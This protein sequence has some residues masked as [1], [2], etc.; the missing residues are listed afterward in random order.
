[1][2]DVSGLNENQKQAVLADSKYLRI[3]AGAGSGKTRVLTMRI[4]HLIQDENI[5]PRQILAITFTN[6]AANEMKERIKK[7]LPGDAGSQ[8]WISTIHSLCVRIL[9]EDIMCMGWP[10]NFTVLDAE[11]Q[12]SILREAYKAIGVD[13]TAFPY[14]ALLD[15]I[16]NNK[17]AEIDVQRAFTLAGSFTGDKTK[18]KV[19]EFYVNRQNQMYALDFDDL[20][21]WT[22]R[23]FRT[24][25]EVQAKWQRRFKFI[26]VDEFQDI[27][28]IQYKLISQL[29]GTENSLYVVGDPDQTIYTWRGAD[30]NII[31]NFENDFKPSRTIMLNENYRS[32]SAILNGANSVIK[33][34]NHRMEK[35]L[36][37]N[38]KS[39]EKITH[40][41]SAG[42]AYEAAWIAAK[43]QELHKAGKAYH[44][45]AILYRSNYLSRS[46]EKGLLDERIPYI[47]YGGTRFYERM[48][49]KDAL[50]YLRMVTG[51][52]DLAFQRVINKPRRGV[53]NKTMDLITEHSV[54]EHK[55]MYEVVRDDELFTGKMKTVMDSFVNMVERWK[56]ISQDGKTQIFELFE[57]IIE[58]SGLRK[59]LEDDKELDR[60]ENLKELID[61][62]KEFSEDYPE[63]SLDE[64]LQLVTLYGDRDETM[65]S[66]FVQLMTVHAAKG[67]EFDTVFVSDMNDGIFPNERAM[68]E[69]KKGIEE[70]RRLAYVA[71]TRAKN[72]LFLCEAGGYSYILQRVRTRSRFIDEID[73]QYIEHIG[74]TFEEEGPRHRNSYQDYEAREDRESQGSISLLDRLQSSK[75]QNVELKKGEQVVHA[76]FGEGIVISCKGGIAEIAFPYPFGIKKIAAGHP[77]LKRKTDL[78]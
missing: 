5:L 46:L 76:K 39:D 53:G 30:V 65:N 24:F 47:I 66:D 55:T 27:D 70:E 67:L 74:A 64:Y 73:E 14:P 1:M 3:V 63:S 57:Q 54:A 45:I 56:R 18:A 28:K 15:Y 6:K 49:V 69:G 2:I 9:R 42:D 34:N 32:T 25:A 38:R 50:C 4:V 21:L 20:I 62:V 48:E 13:A 59:A 72:K 31:M 61:D 12:K 43:I 26:H 44:D 78:N 35:E 8:P 29:A 51:A 60:I 40:Y 52:D 16:S 33:N 68:N 17:S 37:T 22:V 58:E 10:R 36:Y 7:M 11:D 23:M 71:F 77:S 19:Y 75:P 41:A